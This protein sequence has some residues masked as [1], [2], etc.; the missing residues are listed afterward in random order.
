[1]ETAVGEEL[2]SVQIMVDG[3][4]IANSDPKFSPGHG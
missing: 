4:C 2:V 3:I 1:M